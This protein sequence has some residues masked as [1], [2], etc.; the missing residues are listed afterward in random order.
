MNSS[1][2][3]GSRLQL[4]SIG[5]KSASRRTS[6]QTF[7]RQPSFPSRAR[8]T[9]SEGHQDPLLVPNGQDYV[10]SSISS[11]TGGLRESKFYGSES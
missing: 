1:M 8:V 3:F 5:D 11:L 2:D 10:S 4:P 6:M 7:Q 9:E